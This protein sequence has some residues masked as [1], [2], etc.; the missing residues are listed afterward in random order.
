M[1]ITGLYS[2]QKRLKNSLTNANTAFIVVYGRRGYGKSLL[3]K[4]ALEKDDV[5]FVADQTETRHQIAQFAKVIAGKVPGFDD[6]AYTDWTSLFENLNLRLQK[7]LTV[8][9]NEFPYLVKSDSE[10]PAIIAGMLDNKWNKRF[11]LIICGSS[12]QLMEELVSETASPLHGRANEVFKIRA[13]EPSTLRQSL[14]CSAVEAI[15]EYSVWGGSPFYWQLRLKEKSLDEAVKTH[16]LSSQGILYCEPARLFVDEI[17]D[18]SQSFSILSLIAAGHNRLSRIAEM[19]GKPTTS[20]VAPLDRLLNLGY[21]EREVSF[22][23]LRHPKKSFYQIVDPFIR[24]YFT[25]VTP[26]RSAIELGRTENVTAQLQKQFQSY[27]SRTWEQ[28]CRRAVSSM[29]FNGIAFNPACRWWASSKQPDGF[30]ILAESVD[31][32]YLLVGNCI[33][34][35]KIYGTKT[36]FKEMEQKAASLPFR[37]NRTVIPALFVREIDRKENNVYT[38]NDLLYS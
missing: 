17:K 14:H 26:N 4:Q 32:K 20:I 5:Y 2:E 7:R 30:D 15:E 19:M 28:V 37:N 1:Q 13:M 18:L 12:Q 36:I 35:D 6:A 11:N 8:C 33:W 38:P 16:L 9:I 29:R 25:F 10:L 3:V 24:F 31:K 27:V 23:E 21:V 22:T 34:G